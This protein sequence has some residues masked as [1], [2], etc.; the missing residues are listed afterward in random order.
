MRWR[1]LC[2]DEPCHPSV[3]GSASRKS[4]ASPIYDDRRQPQETQEYVDETRLL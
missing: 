2:V 1:D 4:A 3:D